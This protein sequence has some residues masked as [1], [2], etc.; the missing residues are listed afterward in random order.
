MVFHPP[1]DRGPRL[2]GRVDRAG[3]RCTPRSAA[4]TA[5]TSRLSG[6]AELR[7]REPAR[8]KRAEGIGHT[9]QVVIAVD[10]GK[11]TDPAVLLP[12]GE[13]MLAAAGAPAAMWSE[14]LLAVRVH[15]ARGRSRPRAGSRSPTPRS[16]SRGQQ[17]ITAAACQEVV[18]AARVGP[19]AMASRSRSRGRSRKASQSAGVR[20]GAA[21]RDRGR[22]NR[23]VHRVRLAAGDGAT[24]GHRRPVARNRGRAYRPA[25]AR[26]PD[27]LV[28][29]TSSRC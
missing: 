14:D 20:G 21:V 18:N 19:R 16:T 17:K 23:S 25:V 24:A 2:A 22:R 4:H 8:A 29:S 13:P 9:E 10:H 6:N 26:D 12:G 5:T 27:G 11:V 15:A 28:H 1:P 3:R 7:R